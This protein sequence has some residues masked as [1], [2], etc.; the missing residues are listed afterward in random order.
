MRFVDFC[1]LVASHTASLANIEA[2]PTKIPQLIQAVGVGAPSDVVYTAGPPPTNKTPY[3]CNDNNMGS[4]F[5]IAE[6]ELLWKPGRS[7]WPE[8]W[9]TEMSF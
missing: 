7:L 2:V 5:P 6:L 4:L 1:Q 9:P 3:Y 8:L